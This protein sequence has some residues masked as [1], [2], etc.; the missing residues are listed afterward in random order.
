[1][2]TVSEASVTVG[3]HS[4]MFEQHDFHISYAPFLKAL[5]PELCMG[6]SAT[7]VNRFVC[8]IEDE[9]LLL[10]CKV[11]YSA[12]YLYLYLYFI[13]TVHTVVVTLDFSVLLQW[14]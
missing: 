14:F 7:E 3:A 11:R 10:C 9:F 6:R 2:P 13:N 5:P 4:Y 12:I 1:M 8:L